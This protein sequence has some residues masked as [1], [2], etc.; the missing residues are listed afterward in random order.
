MKDAIA[1]TPSR[2]RS[3]TTKT[4]PNPPATISRIEEISDLKAPSSSLHGAAP[5]D[6]QKLVPTAAP[7]PTSEE[8]IRQRAY[9]LYLENGR[10]DGHAE[11]HWLT[12]ERELARNNKA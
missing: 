2:Q 4:G 5:N 11:E 10:E 9:E 8:R 12:A 1:A 3:A 7:G 6:S